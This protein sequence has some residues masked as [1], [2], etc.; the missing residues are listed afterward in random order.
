MSLRCPVE[1][2]SLPCHATG[3]GLALYRDARTPFP[4]QLSTRTKSTMPPG[5]MPL[6]VPFDPPARLKIPIAQKANSGVQEPSVGPLE[7]CTFIRLTRAVIID[8]ERPAIDSR[9]QRG[10]VK[11][12]L[13]CRMVSVS[14]ITLISSRINRLQLD[15][16]Q[17]GHVIHG[18]PLFQRAVPKFF[19]A[20][21][22]AFHRSGPRLCS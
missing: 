19:M 17:L 15:R 20:T 5:G 1:Q 18:Q 10:R 6:V 8:T 3:F 4:K 11:E 9:F 21:N 16:L 13:D 7:I 2:G 14:A 12:R 22:K